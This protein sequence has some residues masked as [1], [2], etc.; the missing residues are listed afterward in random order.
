MMMGKR[1]EEHVKEE[2]KSV[3]RLRRDTKEMI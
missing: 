2:R 1:N 3:R